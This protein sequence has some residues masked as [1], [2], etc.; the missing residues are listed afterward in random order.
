[1]AWYP[2]LQVSGKRKRPSWIPWVNSCGQIVLEYFL[3]G[4][5]LTVF[6]VYSLVALGDCGDRTGYHPEF[7]N[8]WACN[9]RDTLSN[10]VCL[11]G[12]KIGRATRAHGC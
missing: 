7:K 5:A 2:L 3:I 10:V 6:T 4:T 11:A 8:S 1:M 12:I 9:V